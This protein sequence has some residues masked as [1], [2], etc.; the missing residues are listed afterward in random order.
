MKRFFT[1]FSKAKNFYETHE[2]RIA[3]SAMV[4]GFI[5]DNLT[6]RRIDLLVE[7]LILISYILI[8]GLAI[9]VINLYDAGEFKSRLLKWLRLLSPVA[10]QFAFGGLFSGF[11]VFYF[12]SASVSA[13]WPFILFLAVMMVGN[14]IFAKKFERMTFQVSVF[15]IA[16]FSFFIYCVPI[17]LG[18]LG[19]WVFLVSALC[20]VVAIILFVFLLGKLYPENFIESKK[21]IWRSVTA[22]LLVISMGYFSNIIPPIPLS[23]KEKA[24]AYDISRLSDGYYRM[25]VGER[26]WYQRFLPKQTVYISD[27]SPIYV[28]SSVFAPTRLNTD[29]VH[30]WQVKTESGWQTV[31][32][33][34]FSVTGGADRGYRGYSVKQNLYPGKWRVNIETPRGATIGRLNF[35]IEEV[36][37]LPDVEERIY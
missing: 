29:I 34:S 35:D 18:R 25:Y 30:E 11:F 5:I 6:L 31:S 12:R 33:I 26:L 1:L 36:D 4:F 21:Y 17:I 13:S 19:P 8:A 10:I 22:I 2:R 24:I 32:R 15:F 7:N 3:I 14:E 27:G 16:L 28:F 37:I 9:V 23:I 20:S